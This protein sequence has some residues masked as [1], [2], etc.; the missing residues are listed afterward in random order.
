MPAQAEVQ[1]LRELQAVF[2]QLPPILEKKYLKQL[3]TWG[4]GQVRTKA[5][6]LAPKTTTTHMKSARSLAKHMKLKKSIKS[7]KVK[8]IKSKGFIH[9]RVVGP[10]QMG[11]LISGHRLVA[12][13]RE[14]GLQVD[15]VDDFME[16][17]RR[18]TEGEFHAKASER[19]RTFI[20]RDAARLGKKASQGKLS[21]SGASRLSVLQGLK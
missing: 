14:T 15:P 9:G 5:R 12:W 20:S 21:A 19:L 2:K 1:G 8:H 17:A 18:Q 3:V 10:P 16:D 6:K 13:G 11:P 7:L 4:S